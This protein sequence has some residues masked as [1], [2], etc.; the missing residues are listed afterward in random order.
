MCRSEDN[1]ASHGISIF[2]GP[3]RSLRRSLAFSLALIALA[4]VLGLSG[5]AS[6]AA[7][8]HTSDSSS[9]IASALQ[10]FGPISS[11]SP[12]LP[13]LGKILMAFEPNAGQVRSPEG[14]GDSG[15]R[16]LAHIPGGVLYFS[17]S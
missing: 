4:F 9:P 12:T 11:P 17:P 7:Q 5:L 6:V 10:S 2:C 15:V 1:T 13:D 8:R 3:D 16:Y 14:P